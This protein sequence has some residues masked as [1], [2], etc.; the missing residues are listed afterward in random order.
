[1][2]SY[3]R[4]TDASFAPL[5]MAPYRTLSTPRTPR[6]SSTIGSSDVHQGHRRL[7]KKLGPAMISPLQ[8]IGLERAARPLDPSGFIEICAPDVRSV[9]ESPARRSYRVDGPLRGIR[10]K[11]QIDRYEL[12]NP[13]VQG[14]GNMVVLTFNLRVVGQRKRVPLELHGSLPPGSAWM[15]VDP[16]SLR[17]R[18]VQGLGQRGRTHDPCLVPR[19]ILS[20]CAQPAT[21]AD[22]SASPAARHARSDSTRSGHMREASLAIRNTVPRDRVGRAH[23]DIRHR[24]WLSN[25]SQSLR[26][27]GVLAAPVAPHPSHLSHPSHPSHPSHRGHRPP[28]TQARPSGPG[29]VAMR[30]VMVS[31]FRS[32][33]ATPFREPTAA[34]AR[35]PS[36][37]IWIPA[38]PPP[39]SI[40]LTS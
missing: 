31:V 14:D 28:V 11:I 40:R 12:L 10:G 15:A 21:A 1:M 8:E 9:S 6:T 30:P 22:I 25:R 23:R 35:E 17:T 39:T 32:M 3:Q 37:D 20:D 5:R 16:D 19:R 26:R 18:N 13:L 36:G 4:P 2:S 27:H 33:I 29:P 34:N 24:V 7:L 38:A